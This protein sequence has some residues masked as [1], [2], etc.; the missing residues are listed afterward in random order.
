[1]V[2]TAHKP[3][4]IVIAGPNGSG[5]TSVTQK[6]LHHEWAEGTLYVN[7]DEVA[8][9]IFGDWNSQEAVLKAAVYCEKLRERYLS[10]R[11]SF[12]FETVFSTE[13][14]IDFLIR[15]KQAGFFIRL[16]FIAT[17][18]PSINASRIARRVI[19]GGHDVPI[20]KIIS[21]YYKSLL[22]CEAIANMVDRLYVYDNSIDG[23]DARPLFRLSNGVLIKQYCADIPEWAQKILP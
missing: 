2:E 23:V 9:E 19:E 8:K 13:D 22:N 15:A 14:K 10:E 6:F 12:V 16:F 1:M 5:K 11:K 18:H 17:S 20:N 3:E 7:P 21:R 4:M